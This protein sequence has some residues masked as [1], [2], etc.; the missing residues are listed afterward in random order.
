MPAEGWLPAAGLAV[1]LYLTAVLVLVALRRRSNARAL[2]GF[3][4]DCIVLVRRR[5]RDP[6]LGRA[7]RLVLVALL[8][9]LAMPIDLVPD[10]VPVAGQLDD[11]IVGVLAL[12]YVL[13]AGG[14]EM[15]RRHWPG[16]SQS[17]RVVIRLAAGRER[18]AD[19]HPAG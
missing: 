16:P 2:A 11:A 3:L 1:G 14:V 6:S 7:P 4:P 19:A 8:A 15:L 9:Y 12:R 13:R 18:A 5:L 17:L 10:F